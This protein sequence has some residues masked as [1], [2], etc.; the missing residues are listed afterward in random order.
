MSKRYYPNGRKSR[1]KFLFSVFPV[2]FC[3]FLSVVIILISGTWKN[4]QFFDSFLSFMYNFQHIGHTS[5]KSLFLK[6][7]NTVFKSYILIHVPEKP[8]C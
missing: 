7:Y 6:Y 1:L 4:S 3:I 2:L 8:F 5:W